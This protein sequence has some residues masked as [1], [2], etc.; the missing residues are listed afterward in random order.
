MKEELLTETGNLK[1]E[2]E[3]AQEERDQLQKKLDRLDNTDLGRQ[4][5]DITAKLAQSNKER[6]MVEQKLE[7]LEQAFKEQK[8]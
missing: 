1:N 5:S 8:V 7:K 3:S 6:N 4:V 2:I